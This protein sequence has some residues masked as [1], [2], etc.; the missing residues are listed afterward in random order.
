MKPLPEHVPG[1]VVSHIAGNHCVH[2]NGTD[3]NALYGI[4]EQ[5]VARFCPEVLAGEHWTA[6]GGPWQMNT[7]FRSVPDGFVPAGGTPLD[8]FRAKF[9]AVKY[10]IDPGTPQEETAKFPTGPGLFTGTIDGFPVVNGGTLSIHRPLRVGDHV[11]QVFW[12]MSAEHCDGFGAGE[13]NLLPAG[14]VPYV[15]NTFKVIAPPHG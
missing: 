8:D 7:S 4:S 1:H 15:T 5:I 11:I 10:V 6:P 2:P 3:L 13:E 14:E 12:V 9:V